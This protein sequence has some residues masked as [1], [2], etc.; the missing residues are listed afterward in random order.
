MFDCFLNFIWLGMIERVNHKI[1]KSRVLSGENCFGW[2]LVV[3]CS[4]CQNAPQFYIISLCLPKDSDNPSM[5]SSY[6]GPMDFDQFK[7]ATEKEFIVQALKANQGRINQT[8]AHAGIPK[9][10]LLRKIRKYDINVKEYTK[11]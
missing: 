5:A 6:S 10:T 4:G 8:V 9:N 2:L 11:E 1:L 3:D 7:E